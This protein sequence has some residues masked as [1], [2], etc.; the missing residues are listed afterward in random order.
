MTTTMRA[1]HRF[2]GGWTAIKLDAITDYL[3]FY[4]NALKAKPSPE[5]PFETWYIDAFAGTGDRTVEVEGGDLFTA[6]DATTEQLR[7]VGS[8]R[9]AIAIDPDFR[10]LVF[11]EKDTKRFAA[12]Q[13]LKSGFP[14]RDITCVRGDANDELRSIFKTGAWEQRARSR[15][16]RAVVFLEPYGMSVR[17]T[18]FVSSPTTAARTSG[19]CSRYMPRSGS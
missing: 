15:L 12:L 19:I 13:G 14:H 16:Q 6:Q 9:R 7:L 3:G 2:G 17:G 5:S 8:A 10:H 4:T 18:L 11:I 1:E